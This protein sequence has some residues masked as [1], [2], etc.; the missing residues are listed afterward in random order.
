MIVVVNVAKQV[1][2]QPAETVRLVLVGAS[3]KH[4]DSP[5]ASNQ[6]QFPNPA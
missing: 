6:E 1:D 4:V 5:R 2:A 3:T